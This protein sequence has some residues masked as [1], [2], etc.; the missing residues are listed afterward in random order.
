MLN[1]FPSPVPCHWLVSSYVLTGDPCC[2]TSTIVELLKT[3]FT[4]ALRQKNAGRVATLRKDI[5]MKNMIN[6][7][8]CVW[9]GG[10][11]GVGGGRGWW[12]KLIILKSGKNGKLCFPNHW[13]R[14]YYIANVAAMP[15]FKSFTDEV[16]TLLKMRI[17]SV[18]VTREENLQFFPSGRLVYFQAW[19]A[20]F[21]FCHSIYFGLMSGLWPPCYKIQIP[22]DYHQPATHSTHP[23]SAV[24]SIA[25]WDSPSFCFL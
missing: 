1:F 18:I 9:G 5:E 2:G 20:N 7:C 4:R 24:V 14:S 13:R 3:F 8:V 10:A 23:L 22:R 16:C 25:P 11:G 19:T 21:R 17:I 6:V 15:C 12:S